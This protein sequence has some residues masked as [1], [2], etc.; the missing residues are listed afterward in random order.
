MSAQKRTGLA[1]AGPVQANDKS[2]TVLRQPLW[3]CSGIVAAI[4]RRISVIFL[5]G[6]DD[7]SRLHWDRGIE[8]HGVRGD[9]MIGGDGG[10]DADLRGEDDAGVGD[11]VAGF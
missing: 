8:V 3:A 7:L 6:V 5:A 10:E 9:G 11:G 4:G 1:L 2:A